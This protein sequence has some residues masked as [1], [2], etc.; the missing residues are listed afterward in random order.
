MSERCLYEPTETGVCATCGSAFPDRCPISGE[1]PVIAGTTRHAARNLGDAVRAFASA[2]VTA[3]GLAAMLRFL[4]DVIE[5]TV[6][7]DRA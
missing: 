6:D 2:V 4:G 5:G 3:L 7:D 1:S